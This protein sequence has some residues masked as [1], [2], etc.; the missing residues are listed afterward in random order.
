MNDS[1]ESLDKKEPFFSHDDQ[2]II[3]ILLISFSILIPLCYFLENNNK[4][5]SPKKEQA[6]KLIK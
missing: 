4:S 2:L 6:T 3:L 1:N 5:V